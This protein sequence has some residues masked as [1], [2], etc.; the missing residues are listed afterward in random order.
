M[1]LNELKSILF[2]ITGT[3]LWCIVYD[4]GIQ[5]DVAK[6]SAEYVIKNYGEHT[7]KRIYPF[8]GYLIIEI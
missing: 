3:I 6:G 8:E 2:S 4:T 5:S 7:I 1:K